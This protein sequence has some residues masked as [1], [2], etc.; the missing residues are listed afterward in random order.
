MGWDRRE[1]G[2][3]YRPSEGDSLW[4]HRGELRDRLRSQYRR[5]PRA[6]EG[7]RDA[8]GRGGAFGNYAHVL[9]SANR[10]GGDPTSRNAGTGTRLL[11]QTP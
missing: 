7:P 11:R 8:S 2:M 5:V 9:R 1:L 3:H 6:R 4:S 10:S